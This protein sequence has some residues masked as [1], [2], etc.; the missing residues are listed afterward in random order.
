MKSLDEA[1]AGCGDV[2]ASH[3][4]VLFVAAGGVGRSVGGAVDGGDEAL[5]EEEGLDFFAADVCEHGVVDEDAGAEWLAA[6]LFHFPAEG[7]VLDDVLFFEREVVFAHDGADAFAPA[8]KCFEVGG[9]L[10]FWLAH[11]E[12]CWFGG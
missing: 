4:C 6:F 8:A 2:A 11:G 3:G 5:G 9:D 10:R 7:R 1:H 12:W